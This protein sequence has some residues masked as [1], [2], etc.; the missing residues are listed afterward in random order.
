MRQL[1]ELNSGNHFGP[2]PQGSIMSIM[3]QDGSKHTPS[4]GSTTDASLFSLNSSPIQALQQQQGI[5]PRCIT[6]LYAAIK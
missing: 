4:N 3:K 5:I 6:E 1:Q 2:T